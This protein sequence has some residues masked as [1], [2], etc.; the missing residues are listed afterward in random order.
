LHLIYPKE[1]QKVRYKCGFV[2]YLS[3]KAPFCREMV[4]AQK[5]LLI[6]D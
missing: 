1:I 4:K 2:G 3:S 6:F 5:D